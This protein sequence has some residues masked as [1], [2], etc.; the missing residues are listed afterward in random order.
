MPLPLVTHNTVKIAL[1]SL[2]KSK[3]GLAKAEACKPLAVTFTM[4]SQC[5]SSW[6]LQPHPGLACD[7]ESKLSKKPDAAICKA[8]HRAVDEMSQEEPLLAFEFSTRFLA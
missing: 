3:G 6:R 4:I 2:Y 8:C 7:R 5:I 1:G